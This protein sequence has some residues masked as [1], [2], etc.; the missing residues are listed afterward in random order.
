MRL[1][2]FSIQMLMLGQSDVAKPEFEVAAIKLL[3]Q[4]LPDQPTGGPGTKDPTTIR[5]QCYLGTMVN[6]AFGLKVG[7]ANPSDPILELD[8]T[9]SAHGKNTGGSYQ[10][11]ASHHAASIS[12]GTLPPRLP[13][14]KKGAVGI[15]D[16]G[17]QKRAEVKRIGG[18]SRGNFTA[19]CGYQDGAGRVS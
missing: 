5:C 6:A 13:F 12:E 7:E 17:R 18:R 3:Q 4:G 19:R 1:L 14:R 15:S 16:G 9:I 2:L 8:P 10:G 11:T